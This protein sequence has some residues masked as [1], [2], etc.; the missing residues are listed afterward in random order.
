MTD[1]ETP[2]ILDM[3]DE[4]ALVRADAFTPP[5]TGEQVVQVQAVISEAVRRAEAKTVLA[6]SAEQVSPEFLQELEKEIARKLVS[7]PAQ[8]KKLSD[9]NSGDAV[10]VIKNGEWMKGTVN[11]VEKKLGMVYVHTE[12]GPVTI[13]T[14]ANIRPRQD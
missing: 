4:P 3:G 10:D 11:G 12:R 7:K 9:Y 13:M 14:P 2:Q 8:E 5:L 1:I 6:T